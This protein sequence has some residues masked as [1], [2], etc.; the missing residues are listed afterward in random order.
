MDTIGKHDSDE[1]RMMQSRLEDKLSCRERFCE[2]GL[3]R[4]KDDA[5]ARHVGNTK[6]E[7][8]LHCYVEATGTEDYSANKRRLC[9]RNIRVKTPF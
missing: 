1:R 6:R 9:T 2:K 7:E 5:L 4:K 3:A 8:T